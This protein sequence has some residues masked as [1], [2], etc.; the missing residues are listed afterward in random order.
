[1]ANPE[2]DADFA[3]PLLSDLRA[4]TG[5]A[6]RAALAEEPAA[7]DESAPGEPVAA[8]P[9]APVR[10][11]VVMLAGNTISVDARVVKAMNTVN[12]FGVDVT[13]IG[14][15]RRGFGAVEDLGDGLQIRRVA[16]AARISSSGARAHLGRVGAGVRQVG[17]AA[18]PWFTTDAQYQNSLAR[19][20]Q[21]SLELRANRGRALRAAETEDREPNQLDRIR[22]AASWRLLKAEKALLKGRAG[23]LKV[24]RERA[25]KAVQSPN[26]GTGR[27]RDAALAL[28]R[29][30]PGAARWESVLPQILDQEY[31]IGPILDE[32][33]PGVIHAHDVFMLGIAVRAAER[34]AVDGR[35]VRV[36]Y[37]AH[38]FV[39][40]IPVTAPRELAA[41]VDLEETFI[42][43]ADRV[44]TVSEPLADLLIGAY[45]LHRRPDVVL[46]APVADDPS[47]PVLGIREVCGLADDVPLLVYG[48]GVHAARGVQTVVDALEHLPGVHLAIVV[49]GLY[50]YSKEL[51]RIVAEKG[52]ADRVHFAPF[53]P[54]AFVPRYLSSA[55]L[56]VSP[57]LRAVN[58]DVAV[59]NKF[60]EYL[61]AGLPIVTSDTPAQADLVRELGLG[62]VH[63]AGDVADC[64]RAIGAALEHADALRARIEGD[65]QLRQRFSWSAQ[66]EV[67]RTVFDEVLPDGLP[68]QAWD[69][70]ATDVRELR[71]QV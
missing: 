45:G 12:G 24:R 20:R 55:T 64:A 62:E 60:C 51:Q 32:L 36:I 9:P 57:L 27:G 23:V 61:N 17:T 35:T 63:V 42:R 1:V 18:A 37:D 22:D 53:V 52:L 2:Q 44:I 15:Q 10:P 66:A 19:W 7:P 21:R 38:E 41:Y 40:G 33:R 16:P 14:L 6:W 11:L 5:K 67:L 50:A 48:G 56:G 58:H 46:N 25:R 54:P 31:A 65:A 43:R 8:A 13:A 47:V 68:A 70:G 71:G 28:Y 26:A 30:V 69:E 34:A 49:R 4:V 59:T 39:R 29:A 3:Y